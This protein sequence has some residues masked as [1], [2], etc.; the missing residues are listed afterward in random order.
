MAR[1]VIGTLPGEFT[2]MLGRRLSMPSTTRRRMPAMW[3]LSAGQRI[4]VLFHHRG[5]IP[6]Q[7]YEASSMMYGPKAGARIRDDLAALAKGLDRQQTRKK[8]LTF[9]Y[10]AG[11]RTQFGVQ[12]FDLLS[13]QDRLGA[14]YDTL[15]DVLMDPEH[16][17]P[18]PDQ[19]RFVWIDRNPSWRSD[20]GQPQTVMPFLAIEVKTDGAWAPLKIGGKPENDEGVDFVTTVVASL[21][22]QTRWIT[23]WMTPAEIENDT[24][25]PPDGIP[26]RSPGKRR[27]VSLTR[28]HAGLRPRAMGSDGHCP[29]A[30]NQMQR[31]S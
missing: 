12:A 8:A 24:R 1:S 3:F 19:P 16:G 26:V 10:G 5:G 17:I 31:S 21:F 13:H 2:T 27:C 6:T 30:G 18:I 22:G 7:S 9:Y 14:T 23:I 28:L 15:A 20:P 4:Y 29:R 25:V 11:P